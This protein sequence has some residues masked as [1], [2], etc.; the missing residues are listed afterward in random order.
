M[1]LPVTGSDRKI[2]MVEV[3]QGLTIDLDLSVPNV[4]VNPVPT[5]SPSQGVLVPTPAIRTGPS[6]APSKIPSSSPTV[7]S[8]AAL[9]ILAIRAW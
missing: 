5:S 2:V 7:T 9:G 6:A 3:G 1:V 8:G 4:E